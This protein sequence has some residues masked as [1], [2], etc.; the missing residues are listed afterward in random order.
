MAGGA[1]RIYDLANPVDPALVTPPPAGSGYMHDS[2]S[3]LITDNRTTQ[4]A[5]AHNPCEVLVDFNETSV[6][7]WDVTEKAAPVRLST[8]TYPTATY[9]HSGWPTQDNRFIIVH[10]ELDELRRGLNTH[11]Y[12]LDIADLRTPSLVTSY[13][14]ATTSTDH[15]GYTIGN[16]YYVVALQARSRASSIRPT[17]TSLTEIGSFD[18][19][20]T[21]SANTAGT[22]GAWGVYPFLPSGT[23]LVSDIENGLFLLKRNETLPPPA[24]VPRS[25]AADA[26]FARWRRW[27]GLDGSRALDFVGV[28][29]DVTRPPVA[30][31]PR[32]NPS[33]KQWTTCPPIRAT[34]RCV[35]TAWEP[36]ASGCPRSRSACGITSATSTSFQNGRTIARRAFDLGITH[37]DLANNYGPSPGSAEENFGLL[38]KKDF[39][40]F[41]DEMIISSK[42]GYLMWPGPYGEWGSRKYLVASCDQSLKRMGL[43]Y[44][45]IFYS[46]RFDPDTPLEETMGALDSSCAR[47]ARCMPASRATARSTPRGP[48]RSCAN[49]ARR[50]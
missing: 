22:D 1:F 14:G 26:A 13:T 20:L 8:T 6:D 16:R 9:V 30:R 17:P 34:S 40:P 5:N 48:R 7:L 36:A 2:T 28:V 49:S 42:A 27:R 25:A 24:A 33:K 18:T 35:T 3:M 11:I 15:N 45:D 41:R 44:V 29:R 32:Q 10:D 46:H 23:L 50:A 4:C 39:H 37:F 19:Y 43:P 21:P 31:R 47:A 38:M 12:T